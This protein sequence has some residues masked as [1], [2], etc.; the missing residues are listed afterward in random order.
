MSLLHTSDQMVP[1]KS[2]LAQFNPMPQNVVS[3]GAMEMDAHQNA[4]N[5]AGL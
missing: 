2:P 5:R 1:M 4:L 3:G